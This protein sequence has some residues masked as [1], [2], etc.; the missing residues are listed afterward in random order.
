MP[1][2]REKPTTV[3]EKS[4]KPKGRISGKTVH[5]AGRQITAKYRKELAQHD[6][7]NPDNQTETETAVDCTAQA[8]GKAVSQ[9]VRAMRGTVVKAAAQIKTRRAVGQRNGTS[10]NLPRFVAR[11]TEQLPQAKMRRF[12]IQ[13]YHKRYRLVQQRKLNELRIPR[14]VITTEPVESSRPALTAPKAG[15]NIY[16]PLRPSINQSNPPLSVPVG[17]ERLV[18]REK[19]HSAAAPKIKTHTV[20]ATIKTRQFAE[21]RAALASTGP[22]MTSTTIPTRRSTAKALL[23]QR[24]RKHAQRQAQ[25]QLLQRQQQTAKT[26]AAIAKRLGGA[27]VQT[28]KAMVSAVAGLFG[29]GV[30]L[31]LVC[32]VML[33]AAV[34]AS[35]FGILFTTEPSPGSITLNAAV[36]QINVEY[37]EKLEELQSGDYDSVQLHGAPPEWRQVVAVFAA[38][39][40]GANDGVDV[41]TL[42]E[43]RIDRLRKVFW[44]MTKITTRVETIDH[45]D[46][47]ERILHITITAKTVDEMR[48]IYHFTKYQN[49]GLDALLDEMGVITG[50]LGDLNIRQEDAIELLK[51]LPANLSPERRAVIEHALTL[52]G[53][54]NYFWGGKSLVLGWDSRWGTT[55]Q[56]TAAGSSSSGTY[57]PYGLDCSGFVD[58]AF[59]N[60]TGGSYIIGHGGGAASQHSYCTT[61]SWNQAQPGDLVFYPGDTHVGIVGG[62][63]ANGNLLIIH[64][65][66]GANN[67]VITGASGFTS[68]GRPQYFGR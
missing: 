5:A 62:R 8:A 42:D 44:D 15:E 56:V 33:A 29:G 39:T 45:G 50:L 65:A 54:V 55:M 67:I 43:D 34:V 19:L 24:A 1:D 49:E 30:L 14:T 23:Q 68:I 48:T 26:T 10:A 52:V 51:N 28:A 16:S 36:A 59:Y 41:A 61:I 25:I 2:I 37:N 13:R 18:I 60:A 4:A 38:K 46:S 63:D 3:R 9:S 57:R 21:S 35:P 40:A 58:W 22:T 53:K 6:E 11:Q 32:V 31:M 66:N 7:K 20:N 12:V 27:A 17:G 64:C 47:V